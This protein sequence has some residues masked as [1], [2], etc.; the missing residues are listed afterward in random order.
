[1][2]GRWFVRSLIGGCVA[3]SFVGIGWLVWQG[4]TWIL[5]GD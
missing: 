4:V 2:N 5:K 3:W 1:M